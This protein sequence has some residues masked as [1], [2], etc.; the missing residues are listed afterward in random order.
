MK[1]FIKQ[2]PAIP[3]Y[4]SIL[5][6]RFHEILGDFAAG[7][8]ADVIRCRWLKYVRDALKTAWEQYAAS[9][10]SGDAWAIRALAK[11]ERPVLVKVKELADEIEKYQKQEVG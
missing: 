7:T 4:W 3:A 6:S 9:I 11:A 8:D 1:N 5:E 2:I 10:D